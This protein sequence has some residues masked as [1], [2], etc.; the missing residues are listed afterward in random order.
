MATS[1]Q[2]AGQARAEAIARWER[3][4]EP[5][6]RRPELHGGVRL[7]RAGTAP[8]A[9]AGGPGDGATRRHPGPPAQGGTRTAGPQA[10]GRR[11]H[12]RRGPLH[13]HRHPRPGARL[14]LHRLRRQPSNAGHTSQ[15]QGGAGQGKGPEGG[16]STSGGSSGKAEDKGK[17]EHEGRGQGQGPPAP[18]AAPAAAPDPSTT[19]RRER[20]GLHGRRARHRPRR[21]P[22]CA[23]SAGRGLRHLPRHQRLQRRLHGHRPRH[24]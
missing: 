22:T 18:R 13:R 14:Q 2:G 17:G 1:R 20:P 19:D 6:P 11:R 15:T 8:P 9:A 10:A 7:G 24:A 4:C 21:P 3:N 16:E 5:R 12:G 23:D